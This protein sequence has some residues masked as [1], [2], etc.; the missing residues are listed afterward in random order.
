MN[1]VHCGSTENIQRDHII[2]RYKD[3]S[4]ENENIQYLCRQC[5]RKKTSIDRSCPLTKPRLRK[6]RA[7]ESIVQE[8]QNGQLTINF[9]RALAK[10][11]GYK[12]GDT[13]EFEI[14]E[15]KIVLNKIIK[16]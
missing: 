11:M 6:V 4:N 8:L 12:K 13:V 2:P 1:C 15:G 5:H 3:G 9:P 14:K 16:Q 7:N 10:A